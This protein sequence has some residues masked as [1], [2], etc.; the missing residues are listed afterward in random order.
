MV[1][2]TDANPRRKYVGIVF[3]GSTPVF[4]IGGE[5]S[6]PSIYSKDANSNFMKALTF[7][8]NTKTTRLAIYL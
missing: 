8:Q 6:N 7:N 4:Q 1:V 2:S 5:G 3:N